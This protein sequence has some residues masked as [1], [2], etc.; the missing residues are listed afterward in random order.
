LDIRIITETWSAFNTIGI[1]IFT[2]EL[3]VGY[4]LDD[5]GIIA[6]LGCKVYLSCPNCSWGPP[7][8]LNN[9]YQVSFPWVKWPVHDID[10]ST[11]CSTEVKGRVELYLLLL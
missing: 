10:H 1:H 9:G 4:R 11:P 5:P 8:I 6:Q 7:S 3:Q 2:Y